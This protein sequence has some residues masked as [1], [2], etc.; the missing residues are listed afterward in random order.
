[1]NAKHLYILNRCLWGLLLVF[2]TSACKDD[3]NNIDNSA[4]T[5]LSYT[6]ENGTSIASEGTV[7]LTFSKNVRQASETEITIMMR[8]LVLSLLIM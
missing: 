8:L 5:L 7:T 1:M 6:P 4:L 3:D 2:L